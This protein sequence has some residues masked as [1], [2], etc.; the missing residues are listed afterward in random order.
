MEGI[1]LDE[2]QMPAQHEEN[3]NICIALK[4]QY[5]T[6][7]TRNGGGGKKKKQTKKNMYSSKHLQSE[8]NKKLFERRQEHKR[9][10]VC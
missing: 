3:S 6:D 5:Q 4:V 10:A 2:V 1:K 7:S 9:K 8:S